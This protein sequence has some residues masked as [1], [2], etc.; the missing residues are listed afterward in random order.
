[1][2]DLQKEAPDTGG[3][4]QVLFSLDAFSSFCPP[5]GL[6]GAGGIV[7]VLRLCCAWGVCCSAHIQKKKCLATGSWERVGVS[8]WFGLTRVGSRR[9]YVGWLVSAWRFVHPSNSNL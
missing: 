3:G 7:C 2:W 8:A 9:E 1:L 6:R 5:G 4:G